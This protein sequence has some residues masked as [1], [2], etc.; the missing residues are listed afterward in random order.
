MVGYTDI[1]C[2]KSHVEFTFMVIWEINIDIE[3]DPLWVH[4]LLMT[5]GMLILVHIF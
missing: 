1:V 2:G 3:K 4:I 5:I